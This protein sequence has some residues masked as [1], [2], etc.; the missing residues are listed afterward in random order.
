MAFQLSSS[1]TLQIL[2]LS[3]LTFPLESWD[4]ASARWWALICWYQVIWISGKDILDFYSMWL[5][6]LLFLY[7]SW[8]VFIFRWELLWGQRT[9]TDGIAPSAAVFSQ[10]CITVSN[11]KESWHT[12]KNQL[13][14]NSRI[15]EFIYYSY[16]ALC[17]VR[18][19]ILNKR[20]SE[21]TKQNRAAMWERFFN[22]C[23]FQVFFYWYLQC[24]SA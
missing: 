9:E 20:K 2:S 6:L 8:F 21:A 5:S 13:K 3:C 17:V 10:G 15:L 4:K 7:H 11:K 12:I 18:T 23:E 14:D 1:L 24:S 19:F 22:H 16:C